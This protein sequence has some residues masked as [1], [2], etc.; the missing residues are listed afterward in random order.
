MAI[1]PSPFAAVAFEALWAKLNKTAPRSLSYFA[2]KLS[3]NI[4]PFEHEKFPL[5]VTW[6]T[7]EAD[8]EHDLR[9]CIGTFSPLELEKG[10]TKFALE[11]GL[12]DTRFDPISKSE[13][14]SLSCE[15]TLLSNFTKAND[16]WDWTVGEHGIRI[17]FDHRG[18]YY[19]A[20]FLPHVAS[21]YNWTQRQTLEQLVRK[22]GAR[23]ELDDLDIE[24]T[25]YDGKVYS[26]DWKQYKG[27]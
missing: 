12:H 4:T 8:G 19:G 10:L 5:F 15:V 11:S 2:D 27:L 25:R 13:L 23:A 18:S 6:N 24:L 1:S 21:E 7:V 3:T 9:G 26:I 14:P 17:A 16:I 20:T 22:A